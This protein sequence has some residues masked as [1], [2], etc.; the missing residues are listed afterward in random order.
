MSLNKR[1]ISTGE[2]GVTLS[3][4]FDTIEYTG[5]GTTP[6]NIT[7][8]SFQPDIIW[9]LQYHTSGNEDKVGC[10]SKYGTDG[11]GNNY[12]S[13]IHSDGQLDSSST[14]FRGFLSNGFQVGGNASFNR[15]GTNYVAFCWKVN[16][17]IATIDV[18]SDIGISLRTYSGNSSFRNMSHGLGTSNVMP[19]IKGYDSNYTWTTRAIGVSWTDYSRI[20]GTSSGCRDD[21]STWQDTSANS[22]RVR[23][24]TRE[25]VNSSLYNYIMW[26]LTPISGVSA[27]G[28]YIGNGSA[29]DGPEINV[30]F[31]PSFVVFATAKEGQS[32][33]TVFCTN[34]LQSSANNTNLKVTSLSAASGWFNSNAN[35]DFLS[36][37]FKVNSQ[38]STYN[39]N[40]DKYW[41]M[42]WADPDIVG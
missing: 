7:G 42:A 26:T 30:G 17:N 28:T 4:H 20:S 12:F 33:A 8:L 25:W 9:I 29:T 10:F 31:Q 3:E 41:Y 15:N 14:K 18:N 13:Y 22:T 1:L 21:Y 32:T 16:G 27:M 38:F 34:R 2:G 37:G 40:G 19:I 39:S 35:V 23:L 36:T 24:G 11:N 6:R 5:D